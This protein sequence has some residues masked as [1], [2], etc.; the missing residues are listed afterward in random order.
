[1]LCEFGGVSNGNRLTDDVVC[2]PYFFS[3]V[4]TEP[5]PNQVDCKVGDV[6]AD[7]ATL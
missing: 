5:R 6:D 4:V 3:E 7:P 2:F 1:M